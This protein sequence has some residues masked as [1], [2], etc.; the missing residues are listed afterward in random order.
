MIDIWCARPHRLWTPMVREI[1]AAYQKGGRVVLLVPEQYTLQAERDLM[2][3]LQLPGFFRLEVLSPSR[4]AYR[5]FENY[6]ADERVRI[7]ERGRA[8]TLARALQ[9]AGKQLSFYTRALERPGFIKRMGDLLATVKTVGLTPEQLLGAQQGAG[10]G[11]LGSKLADAGHILDAYEELMAGRFADQQDIHREMLARLGRGGMFADSRVFVYGFDVLTED[12][13][14][15]LAAIGAQADHLLVTLVSDRAQ[16]EDGDAFEPVRRSSLRLMDTLKMRELPHAFRWLPEEPLDAPGEIRHLERYLL[17]ITEAAYADVPQAL[18]VYAAPTPHQEVQHAARQ[19]MLALRR[20]IAPEDIVVLCGSLPQYQGLIASGFDS[21]GIP[22]YV[23]DK[24]PLTAHRMVRCLLAALRCAAD[25][26]RTQDALDLIKSGFSGLTR[27]EGWALE[28]YALQYGIRNRRWLSP[29]ARGSEEERALAEPLRQRLTG[30]VEALHQALVDARTAS[31]SLDA[32]LHYLEAIG[33]RQQA[34]ALEE[35]LMQQG[36]YK[37]A[38]QLRQVWDMIAQ[39]FGQMG[40]LMDE[41]R[42]PLTHFADWLQAGLAEQEIAGLPPDGGHVQVGQLGNLLPHRPRVVLVLGLN[43][44]VLSAP[45]DKLLTPQETVAAEQLYGAHFGL[46]GRSRE[47][48]A[49]LD[50]LKAL[51]APREALYLSY[52]LANEE[53][54]VM[55]PLPQLRALSRLFPL[56]VEEGGALAGRA[57]D[58][59]AMP[60]APGPALEALAYRLRD[61]ALD[62]LWAEAWDWM[63]ADE[64]WRGQAAALAASANGIPPQAGIGPQGEGG[65]FDARSASVSRLEQ[66]AAC[67]FQHFVAHGLRPRQREEWQVE[68]VDTGSFYHEAM[69]RFTRL[70]AQHPAWPQMERGA[71][72]TLMDEAVAP[73]TSRWEDKPFYDTARL[74]K[75]SQ[76]YVQVARRMAWTMTQGAQASQFR[77]G[78]A[79]LRFGQGGQLPP[80]L[81]QMPDGTLVELHGV[82]DR[83]DRYTGPEGDYLRVVDYKSGGARLMYEKLFTGAQMQLLIYLQA[84]LN[85]APGAVPAGAFYQ[86]LDDP[87]ADT[88]DPQ[89]AQAEVLKALRLSGIALKDLQVVTL[90]DGGQGATLG[91]LF[92]KDGSPSK[93]KPLLSEEEMRALAAHARGRAQEFAGRIQAGEIIRE[94]AVYADNTKACDYCRYQG[95]CRMDWQDRPRSRRVPRMTLEELLD[96]LTA[97]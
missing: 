20:G 43:D 31:Q 37:Q 60:L 85:A 64:H 71:A 3:D 11:P 69:E 26:W 2:G 33:V 24:L 61:G 38:A 58:P 67:P 19:I 56:L 34:Q 9:R 63:S 21:W 80:I 30:P 8:V 10:D 16:A 78:G 93:G 70:A 65:L 4:L 52:A 72:E 6:G 95:I 84:A 45:D 7:D 47:Q 39:V 32:A 35:A 5:V 82:I 36:L 22:C 49:A 46:D 13:V 53:G 89:Q 42:I 97:K 12:M 76:G 50:L 14:L 73:I 23:A 81:L 40:A 94:P 15:T 29:F 55:H 59:A 87:L 62:P 54:G 18:R 92:N 74:R 44:G 75:V 48:L 88:D 68:P 25:G 77:P 91:Q 83:L 90:M 96:R 79:E 1:G 17:G 66:F 41:D 28:S 86:R 57:G 51:S 27:E